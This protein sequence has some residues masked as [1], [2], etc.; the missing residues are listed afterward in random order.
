MMIRTEIEPELKVE[1]PAADGRQLTGALFQPGQDR[2]RTVVI[3]PAMG[4]G[5]TYYHDFSR[6]LADRGFTVLTFDYRGI[7]ASARGPARSSRATL[8]DWGRKDVPGVLDWLSTERPGDR[9]LWVG[10]S[11]GTQMLGLTPSIGKIQGLVAITAPSGYWGL[12]SGWTRWKYFLIWTLGFPAAV[13]LLGYFPARKLGQGLDLPGGVARD[14]SRWA[15]NPWYVIDEA[16]QPVVENFA[17]YRNPVLA[18]SFTDDRRATLEAVVALLDRFRDAP[19]DHRHVRPAHF[20]LEPIGHMGFF[21][22]RGPLRD[23]LWAET[24]DWLGSV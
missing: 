19:V 12:W 7:G 4:A 16:G 5:Q 3:A 22:D 9:L 6:F 8:Y 24:A 23:T 1:F 14:W 13:N 21:R 15:C 11:I 10:H 20:G 2:R 17:S 18:Y